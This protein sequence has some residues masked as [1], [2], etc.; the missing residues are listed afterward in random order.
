M[1]LDQFLFDLSCKTT[2]TRKHKYAR[3]NVVGV[4]CRKKLD[5]MSVVDISDIESNGHI[6][7]VLGR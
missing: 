7:A 2:E 1:F 3:Y 6:F 4:L 5:A